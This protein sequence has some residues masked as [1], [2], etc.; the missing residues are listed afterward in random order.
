MDGHE[1]DATPKSAALLLRRTFDLTVPPVAV[2]VQFLTRPEIYMS[3][4]W[5]DTGLSAIVGGQRRSSPSGQ[6]W[7][8]PATRHMMLIFKLIALLLVSHFHSASLVWAKGS[9]GYASFATVKSHNFTWPTKKS[10]EMEG[11]VYLGGL[12]MVHE[13]QDDITCGP[14]MPQGGIQALETMMWTIDEINPRLNLTAGFTLG[15]HILD[16]CDK[17]TYGLEQAVAFIKGNP[18][19]LCTARTPAANP[20]LSLCLRPVVWQWPAFTGDYPPPQPTE[21]LLVARQ[22]DQR[23]RATFS[24][25]RD[26]IY[27]PSRCWGKPRP[28]FPRAEI[29]FLRPGLRAH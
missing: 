23:V 20:T 11:N 27:L 22:K 28:S 17:D 29:D 16:D 3:A 26:P 6:R 19:P 8:R 14:I 5:I 1:L 12:M 24:L 21:L 10:A 18:H 25:N 13:R 2:Y 4:L 9:N 7:R 15:A